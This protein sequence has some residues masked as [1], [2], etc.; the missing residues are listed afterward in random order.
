MHRTSS[1]RLTTVNALST[2]TPASPQETQPARADIRI[3]LQDCVRR[4]DWSAL[5]NILTAYP[6]T[7]QPEG[8]GE[9]HPVLE[10]DLADTRE[11]G[12]LAEHLPP[13]AHLPVLVVRG[14]DLRTP[15]QRIAQLTAHRHSFG[16]RLENCTVEC[17]VI[18]QLAEGARQGQE[19]G[20]PGL[21][22]L[23]WTND[24]L[25]SVNQLFSRDLD[26]Q[27]FERNVA[28]CTAGESNLDELIAQSPRL[29]AFSLSGLIPIPTDTTDTGSNKP[30]GLLSLN[31]LLKALSKTP[32]KQLHL[33][34]ISRDCFRF[35]GDSAEGL[36]AWVASKTIGLQMLHLSR[37]NMGQVHEDPK[38]NRGELELL[39]TSGLTRSEHGPIQLQCVELNDCDRLAEALGRTLTKR[40]ARTSV[41]WTM[42]GAWPDHGWELFS[43]SMMVGEPPLAGG[44]KAPLALELHRPHGEDLNCLATNLMRFGMLTSLRVGGVAATDDSGSASDRRPDVSALE[45]D[46]LLTQL[47]DQPNLMRLELDDVLTLLSTTLP[48][49]IAEQVAEL[50]RAEEWQERDLLR[51]GKRNR[52][53]AMEYRSSLDQL[54]SLVDEDKAKHAAKT[55]Q[56]AEWYAQL[57]GQV[58]QTRLEQ[59]GQ[60]FVAS[61]FDLG[62]SHRLDRDVAA[63]IARQLD[64]HPGELGESLLSVALTNQANQAAWVAASRE[65]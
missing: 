4:K 44:L 27:T 43:R 42:D 18:Q 29:E 61:G 1:N 3:Q 35:D 39:G 57:C 7:Y 34:N 2:A 33:D 52:T 46:T 47:G 38:V 15:D 41:A 53:L 54:R 30:Y 19:A 25:P 20:H 9:T 58:R 51:A 23:A 56:Q 64:R 13:D 55:R 24:R 17:D 16:L 36:D 14:A 37:W 62:H 22:E 48:L 28:R 63:V 50:R 40:N 60:R 21:R 11:L 5:Q 31:N 10:L 8:P 12:D 6:D 45:M 26:D 59:T 32:L 65:V 49:H